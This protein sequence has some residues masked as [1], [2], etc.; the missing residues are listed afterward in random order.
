MPH[1]EILLSLLKA[2]AEPDTEDNAGRT[3]L[4]Y[5][6]M[7]GDI[8]CMSYLLRYKA[9]TRDESLHIAARNLNF[10]AVNLLLDH[11]APADMPG[12]QHC[13]GRTPLAELCRAANLL[14]NPPQLKKTLTVLCETGIDLE[15]TTQGKT[16]VFHALDN[17]SPLKMA[18]ALLVASRPIRNAL[19]DSIFHK[20]S[21]YYSPTAYVRHFRCEECYTN[22]SLD[23]LRRCCTLSPCC[24]PKLEDLLRSYGCKD[25]F[26]DA[27]AGAN[28]PKGWSNPPAIIRNVIQ[29]AEDERRER[30][31]KNRAQREKDAAA[32]AE[33]KRERERLQVLNEEREAERRDLQERL[34]AE[35]RARE[36]RA[37]IEMT[38]IRRQTEAENDRVEAQRRNEQRADDDR[39]DRTRRD[40]QEEMS[41]TRQMDEER[42]RVMRELSNIQVDQRK[43]EEN[44]RR[45]TIKEE[46]AALK[47]RTGMIDSAKSMFREAGYS[48]VSRVGMGKVLGEI[49]EA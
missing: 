46:R 49:D 4:Q 7:A 25:R 37:A 27:N 19:K 48:G 29:D 36:R 44:L 41:R 2:G 16:L 12:T 30:D 11:G 28:Q 18:T 20:N 31:L 10:S 34:D 17:K 14:P 40:F 42:G 6:T 33:R 26:W 21:V 39:R 24:A 1:A 13:D 43:R 5:A 22:R 8:E 15:R 9:D 32:A 3:P 38:A 35:N 23:L 47:E 45:E